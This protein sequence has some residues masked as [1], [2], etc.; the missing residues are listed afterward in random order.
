MWLTQQS[1]YVVNS[2]QHD[3]LKYNFTLKSKALSSVMETSL[4]N[5]NPEFIV[6]LRIRETPAKSNEF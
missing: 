2:E 1:C 3:I 5:E 4:S 6:S